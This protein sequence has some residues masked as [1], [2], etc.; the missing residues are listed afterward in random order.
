[1]SIET[2]PWAAGAATGVG[3]MPGTDVDEALRV[4]FGTL[5][6][7]PF[8]PELPARGPGADL[9]GRA[10][11][12]LAELHVDLQPAGWRFVARSGVDERRA[13]SLLT[14]DLDALE[15]QAASYAGPLKLQVAGP[16]T[17]AATVERSRGG[18]A[19]ADQG[20]VRDIAAALAEGLR[21][22]LADVRRRVPGAILL[23]QLDEPALPAVL[24]GRVPTAS[25]FGAIPAVD[26]PVARD[27][28]AVVLRAVAEAGAFGLVHCCASGVPLGLLV[29][30]GA[31]AVSVDFGQLSGDDDEALG[32][33]VE[34]GA[35]LL[36]GVVPSS[37]AELSHPVRT[38]EPVRRLWQRLRLPPERLPAVVLTP[39]CGLAGASAAHARAALLRCREAAEEL[40]ERGV[41]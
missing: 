33:A 28:L 10:A 36:L 30:A 35:G 34:S 3:S 1:M 39:T 32:T 2:L 15:E 20:A 4:V 12:L 21:T 26:G 40:A 38:V 24:V 9:I 13:T 37:D 11:G 7:L 27:A 23:L 29:E 25:G 31:A 16:W 18:R 41:E 22:H 19:L 5:P 8:L 17:L 6:D 14:R